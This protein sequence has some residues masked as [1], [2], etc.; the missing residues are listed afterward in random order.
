MEAQPAARAELARLGV[1]AVPAVVVGE[2]AV[3]GWNPRGVA[4]LLGI[5]YREPV[6]LSPAELAG[7]LNRILALAQ[8]AT[9]QVPTEELGR[10]TPGRDR[11]VRQ[12]A[13]HIF[14]LSL[15][16]RDG[17]MARRL[18]KAWLDEDAPATLAHADAI[19][20]YGERARAELAAWLGHADACQGPVD[21]YYG[22]QAA[23]ELLERT[24]WHAAQHLRQLH[25]LLEG[26]GVAPDAPLTEADLAGLPLP[27][28]VW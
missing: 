2:R 3:H 18:P 16:Y 24:V 13:Y 7:R 12:L 10:P 28:E 22:P 6:R 11:T 1:P 25:A 20:E 9:R 5:P 19:A 26:M 8:R 27:R 17:V 23:H 4:E 14:R 21:T 15:A